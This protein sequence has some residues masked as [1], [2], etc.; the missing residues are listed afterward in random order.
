MS[1]VLNFFPTL[2]DDLK[3]KIG[4]QPGPYVF[5]YV[6]NGETYI[7]EAISEGQHAS[8]KI[9]DERCVWT[10]DEYD[11][12]LSRQFKIPNP[13]F[14]FGES[15][16]V[17]NTAE[18]GVA[19]EWTSKTSNQRGVINIGSFKR[20]ISEVS[21]QFTKRFNAGT[22]RGNLQLKTILYLKDRG[23][24]SK[25]EI[26]FASELGTVFGNIDEWTAIIDGSG[27]LFP[28]VDRESKSS[29]LWWVECNW[30]NP[31]IDAFEDEN[32]CICINRAHPNFGLLGF[33]GGLKES[34]LLIEII[35]S[36]IQ[37]IIQKV[38]D[39]AYWN[40]ILAGRNNEN[41]SIGQAI[42]YFIHVHG[43]EV[44]SPEGLALSI[45]E[46]FDRTI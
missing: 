22:L 23:Y 1:K 30:I 36:A 11:L 41:G 27:S 5:S 4:F 40:D 7:L 29:P 14:L 33:G 26:H 39:D 12:Q 19:V 13:W 20:N 35:A 18:I 44:D 43:W 38:K 10:A 42:Q 37:I 2:D 21:F 25:S 8:L 31:Q 6:E 9:T 28:I 17:C 45:R 34:P 15:G 3:A 32:V 16:I 46:Y 24:P